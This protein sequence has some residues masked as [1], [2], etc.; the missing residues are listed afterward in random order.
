MMFSSS[1][2]VE[3]ICQLIKDIREYGTLRLER[4]E[5]D[6]TTKLALAVGML[7]MGAILAVFT[8]VGIIFVSLAVA[9]ALGSLI[10]NV[11]LAMFFVALAYF[12]VALIVYIKRDSWIVTP[13]T[14]FF[15]GLFAPEKE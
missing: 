9:Y 14:L 3:L 2:N 8:L 11:A 6:I 10:G 12:C 4:F 15:H 7:C 13:L 5:L 1:K